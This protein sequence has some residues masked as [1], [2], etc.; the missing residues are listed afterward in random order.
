MNRRQLHEAIRAAVSVTKQGQVIIIGSQAILGTYSEEELPQATTMSA[1]LDVAPWRDDPLE[2][3]STDIDA[4][5]GQWSEFDETHGFYIHGVSRSTAELSAG[6]EGRLVSVDAGDGA[7]GLC[8]ERHDVCASK[9][10]RFEPKDKAFVAALADANLIDLEVLLTR[11]RNTETTREK[12]QQA[13][14]W[15]EKRLG[16]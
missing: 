2:L 1:E 10:M 3:L 14:A 6:W 8:L 13:R 16:R 12:R 11:V 7:I 9:L 15:V 5:L 4:Q